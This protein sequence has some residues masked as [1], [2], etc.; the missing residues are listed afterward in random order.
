MVPFCHVSC[1]IVRFECDTPICSNG[2]GGADFDL[3]VRS[4]RLFHCYDP[5]IALFPV[6]PYL[7]GFVITWTTSATRPFGSNATPRSCCDGIGSSSLSISPIRTGLV[8]L[9]LWKS[10]QRDSQGLILLIGSIGSVLVDPVTGRRFVV[11]GSSSTARCCCRRLVV[12]GS[13][14]PAL[15][16]PFLVSGWEPACSSLVVLVVPVASADIEIGR[17]VVV[18]R[19]SSRS[20]SSRRCRCRSDADADATGTALFVAQRKRVIYLVELSKRTA[21]RWG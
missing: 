11:D 8:S 21:S 15:S 7:L 14:L 12:D 19:S 5:W 6:I 2:F 1:R 18:T 4:I 20:S 10:F 13:V 16:T 3:L 17:S 9:S